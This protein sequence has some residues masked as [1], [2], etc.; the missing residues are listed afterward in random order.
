MSTSTVDHRDEAAPKSRSSLLNRQ[1]DRYPANGP[2]YTYL[3]ITVLATVILYYELYIAGAVATDIIQ[4]FGMSFNGFVWVSVIG[5]LV[6]AFASLVAGL[7]DRWGRANIVVIGLVITGLLTAVALPT[8]PN[9][10]AYTVWFAI[11]SIVEGMILVATPA[12]IR[13]FSPQVGRGTA[14]G[15]WTLGPVLGS[16][17]SSSSCR[18]PS[19]SPDAGAHARRGRTPKSTSVSSMRRCSA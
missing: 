19:C 7:A 3:A 8:A 17:G 1:L 16:P 13:D 12:L 15:F 9:G 18:S 5:N 4:Y 11:L 10:T 14:M 6:G 2:R